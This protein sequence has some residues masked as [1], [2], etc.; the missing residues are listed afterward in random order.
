[1]IVG[2]GIAGTSIAYHLAKMVNYQ[3]FR[4]LVLIWHNLNSMFKYY[5]YFDNFN[6]EQAECRFTGKI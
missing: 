6:I 1:M 2:G 5:Q 4:Y 3:N